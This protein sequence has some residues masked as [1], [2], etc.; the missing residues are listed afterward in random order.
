MGN[1]IKNCI[2]A[3]EKIRADSRVR[4]L[5][6]SSFYITSPVS[7]I[8]QNDFINCVITLLWND[9]PEAL[10]SF[11]LK[12]ENEMGRQR[13]FPKGPRNID[14]D[15]IFFDDFVIHTPELIIPHPEAH[16]RK[17][18]IIPT[19]EIEPDIIH[20]LFKKRLRDFLDDIG[21][22]QRVELLQNFKNTFGG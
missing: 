7:Y 20:P 13:F 21:D 15:I 19:I 9:S 22:E 8:A 14:L 17:F 12:I 4:G 1:R 18:V 3:I 11:L 16:K 10:L 5:K 2:A 6:H